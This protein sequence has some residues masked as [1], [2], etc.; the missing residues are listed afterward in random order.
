MRVSLLTAGFFGLL[1]ITLAAPALG[2]DQSYES[3]GQITSEYVT[4]LQLAGR[5]LSGDVLKTTLPGLSE[6]AAQRI[7]ALLQLVEADGLP[8]TYSTVNSEYAR[9]AAE[10][11]KA[12]GVPERLSREAH[13]HFCAGE[14]KVRYEVLLA[15]LVGAKEDEVVSQLQAQHRQAGS[16]IFRLYESQGELAVFDTLGTELKYCLNG[17]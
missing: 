16:A 5:G 12:Q 4:V 15:A 10:V 17:R 8:E 2:A 7:D 9:C 11:F 1:A 3:C 14:N 6:K 13:F